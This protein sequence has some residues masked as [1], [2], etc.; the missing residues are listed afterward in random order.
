VTDFPQPEPVP[1]DEVR[2]RVG[3]FQERLRA[4]GIDAALLVESADLYYLTGTVQDAHLVV[5]ADGPLLLLVRR[6]LGRAQAESVGGAEVRPLR[7]LRELPDAL[8]RAGAG[9]LG[10]ELDVL[11]AGRYLRYAAMFPDA[12]LVDA[13]PALM[14]GRSR[15]SDWEVGRVRA[16]AEQVAAAQH[17]ALAIVRP[18]MTDREL[19]I[20]LERR[21]RLAGH[22]GPMRFRGMN[23]EIFYGAV[24]AGPDAALPAHSDTPLGGPGPAIAVGRGP[25]GAT[26]EPGMAI[27]VDLVGGCDGYLADQTRTIAVGALQ[28]PLDRALATC[29]AILAGIE[30]LLV[31]GTSSELLYRFGLEIA[32]EAGFGDHWMG[33]GPGRV[34]FVGHGVG[35]EINERPFLAQGDTRPLEAGNVIAIE[36]KLVLPGIGAVGRENTY[37]VRPDGPAENLTPDPD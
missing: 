2:R 5:P 25:R 29:E 24:L 16:A 21:M 33:F 30:E 28:A 9:R 34:R 22:Q 12:E 11:P 17:H 1:A 27:T 23:G 14:D 18:G 31:P 19:Q 13:A 6:D 36:P 4:D 7:S 8:G 3:A 32:E 15:K 35:L 37:L 26:I 10:L 20:E